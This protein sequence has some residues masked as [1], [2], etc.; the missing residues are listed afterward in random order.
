MKFIIFLT[1]LFLFLPKSFS[2]SMFK[3]TENGK[4]I[5]G[6]NEDWVSPNTQI[7]FE[8]GKMGE[9]GVAYLGFFDQFPQ[10]GIN[11]AGLVF[12]GFATGEYPVTNT[13]GKI[14]MS[15]KAAIQKIMRNFSGVEEVKNFLSTINLKFLSSSVLMF[16]EKSGK[17]LIVEGDVMTIGEEKFYVQSNF[18]PSKANV[19][20]DKKLVLHYQNGMGFLSKNNP[21]KKVN[22]NFCAKVMENMQHRDTQYTSL[23]N[24][25]DGTIKLYHYHN[26]EVEVV[27]NLKKELKKGAHSYI[28]PEMFPQNTKGAKLY[29]KYNNLEDPAEYIRDIYVK[30]TEGKTEAEIQKFK[31]DSGLNWLINFMGYEWLRDKKQVAG[32]IEIFKFGNEIYPADANLYDSVGE[33]YF[34]AEDYTAAIV[35]YGKSLSLDPNNISAIDQLQRIREIIK[36]TTSEN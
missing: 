6:N 8:P 11:E 23:Y 16:V 36:K 33:A 28:I 9:Y 32:A 29:A 22:M 1:A 26:Y 7:W 3:M 27:I 19:E 25:N 31:K 13:E 21:T 20:E 4:T 10:G 2:C 24:L 17:Y 14:D 15:A 18:I 12:D 5:V 30:G 34:L 35:N